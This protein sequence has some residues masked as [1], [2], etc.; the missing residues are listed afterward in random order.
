[1][2]K[3]RKWLE[4]GV[5]TVR[6]LHKGET[7]RLMPCVVNIVGIFIPEVWILPIIGECFDESAVFAPAKAGSAI[8][9][10]NNPV[11]YAFFM[12]SSLF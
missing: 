9:G 3:V 10:I 8:G 6:N 4:G 7:A 11:V 1:M 2:T 12:V 5:N